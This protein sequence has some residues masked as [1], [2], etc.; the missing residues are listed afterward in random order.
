MTLDDVKV[1]VCKGGC[2]G[3]W[4]DN[5]EIDKFDEAHES[6]G[7]PLLD[8]ER[9]ERIH[10]NHSKRRSCPKCSSTILMRH[11]YSVKHEVE[12]DECPRCGGYWLDY[13]EL[14]QIRSQ[15]TTEEERA[16]AAD[17][18]F[19]D[20]MDEELGEMRRES[21][22]KLEKAQRIARMFRFICPSYYIPGKQS[23]GAF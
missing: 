10:V 9:R 6:R 12:V 14:G 13:G 15:Y 3:V 16:T 22:E 20:L 5:Y 11:F 21:R 18:Y 4:F 8:V 17:A 1:D 19:T 7:E 23:W 2:G